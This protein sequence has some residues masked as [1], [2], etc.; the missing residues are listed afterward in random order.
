MNNAGLFI[1]Q[2]YFPN[3]GPTYQV[4]AQEIVHCFD[5]ALREMTDALL[6]REGPTKVCNLAGSVGVGDCKTMDVGPS[7]V[8]LGSVFC[9]F[10]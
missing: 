9:H 5:R 4:P 6:D 7:A 3:E 2:C 10:I 8:M 1:E